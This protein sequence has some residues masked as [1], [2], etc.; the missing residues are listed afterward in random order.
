M[1]TNAINLLPHVIYVQVDLNEVMCWQLLK[2]GSCHRLASG[3][4][5]SEQF[6]LMGSFSEISEMDQAHSPQKLA[7]IGYQSQVS[8][9]ELLKSPLLLQ[10]FPV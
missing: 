4:C 7:L 1:E 10:H 8:H 9:E 6:C 3:V 2:Q 5:R